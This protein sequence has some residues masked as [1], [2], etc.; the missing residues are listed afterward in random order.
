M[1]NRQGQIAFDMLKT[2]HTL[3]LARL[4]IDGINSGFISLIEIDFATALYE[5]IE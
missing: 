3:Q 2:G 4:H 1:N 5:A